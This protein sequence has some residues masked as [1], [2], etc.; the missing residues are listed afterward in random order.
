MA[1]STVIALV[2]EFAEKKGLP[3]PSAVVGSSNKDA[4]QF[5]ALLKTLVRDLG[6]YSWP[7]QRVR[8]TWTTVA[9]VDQG[10]LAAVWGADFR[11]LV[12]NTLWNNT[13]QERIR[14][15]VTE[16][17]WQIA[18]A[19]AVAGD[20]SIAWIGGGN[21]WLYPAPTAGDSISALVLTDYYVTDGGTPTATISAD[22]NKLLFPDEVVMV[23]LEFFWNKAKGESYEWE[24]RQ[25]MGLI[26]DNKARDSSTMLA[27]D[28]C[29]SGARPGILLPAG[30]VTT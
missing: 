1:H 18:Q 29:D 22:D 20:T 26:G 11:S 14:G 23:G 6:R 24:Y 9:T 19:S 27:L 21:F 5:L 8:K 13:S 30:Y 10:T 12:A 7:A 3:T 16:Q 25:Y 2:Q 15:P 4:K 28:S 17:E